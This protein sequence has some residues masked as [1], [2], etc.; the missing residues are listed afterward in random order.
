MM[1]EAHER[2][3][4]PSVLLVCA[5]P[6]SRLHLGR[7]LEGRVSRRLHACGPKEAA[8][9]LGPE[10][11]DAVLLDLGLCEG[12]AALEWVRVVRDAARRALP[13]LAIF[14]V[15]SD[16]WGSEEVIGLYRAGADG[17]FSRPFE[18]EA[19]WQAV[20]VAGGSLRRPGLGGRDW[21]P[22]CL[23]MGRDLGVLESLGKNLRRLGVAVESTGFGSVGLV[24][25]HMLA[26]DLVV[27]DLEMEHDLR[28][29]DG[30][31]ML[32]ILKAG[33]RTSGAK[34]AM[35]AGPRQAGLERR[36][37]RVG[38]SFYF[39]KE[40]HDWD[41]VAEQLQ[42]HLMGGAVLGHEALSVG[43]VALDLGARRAFVAGA[44]VFLT[45]MEFDLL[46]CLMWNSP[47]VVSWDELRRW[48]CGGEGGGLSLGKESGT[49]H[50]I[51]YRVCRKLGR[52]AGYLRVQRGLGLRFSA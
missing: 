7:G 26:P 6:E 41:A 51:R 39:P 27:L 33:P 9:M 21:A 32:E 24:M 12:P 17:V 37:V 28:G 5:D 10:R 34:V 36:C 49:L 29:L 48:V 8:G 13:K 38:A 3:F 2:P 23:M 45:Q 1:L 14:A 31:K 11:P 22:M 40:A 30:L 20:G 44:E 42:R 50:V 46:A 25:A 52:A 18:V 47:R 16:H 19:L 35:L 43:K 15:S 4:Y